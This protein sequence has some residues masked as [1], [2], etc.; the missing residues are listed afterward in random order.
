VP[1]LLWLPSTTTA[2]TITGDFTVTQGAG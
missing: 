2:P 1:F